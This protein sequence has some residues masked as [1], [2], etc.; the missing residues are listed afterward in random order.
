[1]F[2]IEHYLTPNHQDAYQLWLDGIRDIRAKARIMARVERLR[3]GN[4][5]DCK[6]LRDGVWELRVDCG[7]GYRIYY[8]QIG[9][10]VILLLS[11]GDK[12]RQKTDIARAVKYLLDYRNRT[13]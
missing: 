2:D 13:R 10:C 1:M 11:G 9:R 7:P 4:Y 3:G 8:A 12:R 6:S 5:G